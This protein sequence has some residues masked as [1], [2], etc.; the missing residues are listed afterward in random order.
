MNIQ[1]AERIQGYMA[2]PYLEVLAYHASRSQRVVEIGCWRGRTTRALCDNCSGQVTVVDHF[3]G[4][5]G[6]DDDMEYMEKLTGDPDWLYHEFEHNL[7]GVTNLEICCATSE[8]AA[9]QFTRDHRSFDLIFL[10]GAHDYQSVTRDLK[11]WIPLL[12]DPG[13]FILHDFT[14]PDV[15]RATLDLYPKIQPTSNTADLMILHKSS[16]TS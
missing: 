3:E 5:D 13:L 4:S 12:T 7:Q 10:D 6:I 1:A 8:E 9:T 16:L 2:V 14:F 11:A 15:R